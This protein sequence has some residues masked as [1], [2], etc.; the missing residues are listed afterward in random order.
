MGDSRET[1]RAHV[2][3]TQPLV[4][5]VPRAAVALPLRRCLSGAVPGPEAPQAPARSPSSCK[6]HVQPRGEHPLFRVSGQE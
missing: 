6:V 1:C 4:R 3:V 2:I 5:G